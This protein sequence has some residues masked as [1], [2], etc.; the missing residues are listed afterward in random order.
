ME[1]LDLDFNIAILNIFKKMKGETK[2][3]Y[4]SNNI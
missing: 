2:R 1:L 4:V 3:E